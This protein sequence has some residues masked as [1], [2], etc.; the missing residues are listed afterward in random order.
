[1]TTY[2]CGK[3]CQE[4]DWPDHKK[5]HIR[6]MDEWSKW[7]EDSSL[8]QLQQFTGNHGKVADVIKTRVLEYTMG[9][10]QLTEVL[11][12]FF[13]S[14]SALLQHSRQQNDDNSES[15]TKVKH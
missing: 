5:L 14:N 10:S 15:P 1:M 12:C 13:I 8:E 7:K 3:E 4:A 2:Y 9:N 11:S 6:I